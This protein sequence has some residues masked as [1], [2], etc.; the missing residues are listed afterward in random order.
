L[1]QASEVLAIFITVFGLSWVFFKVLYAMKLL[2]VSRENELAG[3]DMPEMGSLAYPE[4][5]EPKAGA[6]IYAGKSQVSVKIAP[7]ATD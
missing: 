7:S 6:I 3:L 5:W 1:A 2:R 4:D